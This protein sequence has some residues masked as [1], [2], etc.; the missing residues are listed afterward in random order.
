MKEKRGNY[1]IMD[2]DARAIP[3]LT[4]Y[5]ITT[6]GRVYSA[7]T[8]LFLRGEICKTEKFGLCYQRYLLRLNGRN[9][10]CYAHRLTYMTYKGPIPSGFLVHHLDGNGCNNSLSNLQLMTQRDH[11]QKI[12]MRWYLCSIYPLVHEDRKRG[13]SISDIARKYDLTDQIIL[14]LLEKNLDE[15]LKYFNV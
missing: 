1:K 4:G 2:V 15:V 7:Y 9:K 13:M 6:D 3:N 14:I 10:N 5:F 11:S 8:G 12:M